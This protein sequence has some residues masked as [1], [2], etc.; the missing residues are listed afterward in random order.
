MK[1]SWQPNNPIDDIFHPMFKDVN[2]LMKRFGYNI[3]ISEGEMETWADESQETLDQ[4]LKSK[5]KKEIKAIT[6]EMKKYNKKIT[7]GVID[8]EVT[9]VVEWLRA[10]IWP[11]DET[12][13]ELLGTMAVPVEMTGRHFQE[14]LKRV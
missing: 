14:A 11:G 2:K 8:E 10:N 5:K 1:Y 4:I 7:V 6:Q 3:K 9:K 12:L 13:G